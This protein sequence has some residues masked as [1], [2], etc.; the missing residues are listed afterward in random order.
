MTTAVLPDGGYH[1]RHRE[2]VGTVRHRFLGRISGIQHVA[3]VEF[4]PV[5]SVVSFTRCGHRNS[6]W[7]WAGVAQGLVW[8]P[9]AIGIN[10]SP[11][12]LLGA[13]HDGPEA[14]AGLSGG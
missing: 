14:H 10:P 1:R 8:S 3:L 2:Y 11:L 7:T 9:T 6:G 5:T 4:E 13:E 12:R